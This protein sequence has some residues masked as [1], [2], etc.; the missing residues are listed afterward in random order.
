VQ[1][2]GTILGI[3]LTGKNRKAIEERYY[4]FWNHEATGGE[5]EWWSKTCLLFWINSAGKKDCNEKLWQA[6]VASALAELCNSNPKGKDQLPEAVR[7]AEE[8]IASMEN[9]TW[10]KTA[11]TRAVN[12]PYYTLGTSV[13]AEKGTGNFDDDVLANGLTRGASPEEANE[14][15]MSQVVNKINEDEEEVACQAV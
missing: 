5:P 7:I 3:F 14:V 9:V 1:N 4:S 12:D 6:M 13:S 2:L 15:S 8:R 11:T 10:F